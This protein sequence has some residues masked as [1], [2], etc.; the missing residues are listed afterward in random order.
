VYC[1]K[2]GS[3]VDDNDNFCHTCGQQITTIAELADISSNI[4]DEKPI[5]EKTESPIWGI[6]ILISLIGI[7]SVAGLVFMDSIMGTIDDTYI[8]PVTFQSNDEEPQPDNDVL[9]TSSSYAS[10]E[11]TLSQKEKNVRICEQVA[12]EYYETH[13]YIEDNIFDCDNMAMD[14]WNLIESKGI[15]A[16]IAVGNVDI[17]GESLEDINHAWVTAEVSPQTWVAIE[18]T[19][20]FVTYDDEYY[21]G[22]FFDNP[23]NYKSFLNLYDDWNYQSQDYEN[24]R[25]YYNELVEIYNDANYYEQLSLESGMTVARNTLEEK[26]RRFSRTDTELNVLLEFG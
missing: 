12:S 9:V 10:E 5:E 14:V 11:K 7:A 24:Y 4:S 13:T 6:I 22:W 25:L 1:T 26:E 19:G 3:E 17:S 15:N 8:K 18:C 20:G 23:K 16:E 21:S 2:C